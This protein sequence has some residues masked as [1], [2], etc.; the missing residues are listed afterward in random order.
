VWT[1]ALAS[2]IAGLA[3]GVGALPVLV[4][5]HLPRRTHDILLGFAAGVMLAAA[6][7]SLLLP[8]LEVAAERWQS[9]VLGATLVALGFLGGTVGL[10]GLHHAVPHEHFVKGRDVEVGREYR[11]IFLLVLA[12]TLHNFP[13][14]LAVGVAFGGGEVT[15]GLAVTAGIFL[16]NLPEGLIVAVA[17]LGLGYGR[18]RAIGVALGTGA[19]E[20]LGGLVGA[21]AIAVAGA[22][23]PFGLAAAAGA[24]VFVVA[25]EV[26]PEAHQQGNDTP[27]TFGLVI[28]FA[29]MM[30]LDVALA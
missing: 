25:H 21:G 7:F 2:L 23:L 18:W 12:I 27:A 9:P 26:I 4:V 3:A 17:L 5:G 13:E 15:D 30:I 14:G 22:V 20:T 19:V 29:V 16:Q 24:M 11:R 10:Y 8:G 1:G 6:A 28:G